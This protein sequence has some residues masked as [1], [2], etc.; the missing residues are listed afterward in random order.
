MGF[1]DPPAAEICCSS[2]LSVLTAGPSRRI[3]TAM[4]CRSG[5]SGAKVVSKPYA[6]SLVLSSVEKRPVSPENE[7]SAGN[8]MCTLFILSPMPGPARV[9][10]FA[11]SCGQMVCAAV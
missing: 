1:L 2:L 4:V 7:W 5:R 8:T 3:S 11:R 9:L 10:A 6:A